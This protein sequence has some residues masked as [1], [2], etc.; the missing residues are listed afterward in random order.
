MQ[1]TVYNQYSMDDMSEIKYVML[2]SYIISNGVCMG[3]NY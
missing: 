2:V 3:N 1:F